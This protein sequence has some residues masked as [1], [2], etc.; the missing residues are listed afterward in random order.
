MLFYL[1]NKSQSKFG[2]TLDRYEKS[3]LN[4]FLLSKSFA[5]QLH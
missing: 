5:I 4:V 1:V 3:L 2:D